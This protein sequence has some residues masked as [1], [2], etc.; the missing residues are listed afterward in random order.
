MTNYPLCRYCGE[1]MEIADVDYYGTTYKCACEGYKKDVA[2]QI[3]IKKLTNQLNKKEDE[4]REHRNDS[5]YN[6]K[7]KKA[8]KIIDDVKRDFYSYWTE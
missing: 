8:E 2:L 1:P 3:E 7:I 5:M 4:L 6:K